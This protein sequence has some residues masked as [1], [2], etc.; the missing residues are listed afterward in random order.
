MYSLIITNIPCKWYVNNRRTVCK[1]CLY[2]GI[3]FFYKFKTILKNNVYEKNLVITPRFE[4]G[5]DYKRC[6]RKC[7]SLGDHLQ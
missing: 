6:S 4:G 2:Y 1:S 3:I 7:G 5:G